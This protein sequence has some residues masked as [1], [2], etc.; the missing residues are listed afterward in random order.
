MHRRPARLGAI[1][2]AGLTASTVSLAPA[3]AAVAAV[4][5]G[6]ALA[7]V[8]DQTNR[9]TAEEKVKAAAVLGIDPDA[10]LLGYN[11]QQFVFELW[12]KAKDGSAVKA[13]A[14]RAYDDDA[15]DAAYEFIT[16]G[17]FTAQHDD[18]QTEIIAAQG[19]ALRRSVAVKVGLDP[20][21]TALIE[22]DDFD[23]IDVIFHRATAGTRLYEAARAATADG[24]TQQDWTA[25]L[26][27]GAAA[28]VDADLADQIAKADAE[29]AAKLRAEQMA[30]AKRSLLQL[31]L[32]PVSE[33]LINAPSRQFVLAVH[34]QAKG[35]EVQLASQAVLNAPD[36]ELAKALDDFILTGGAAANTRDEQAA[37]AKELAGY[38]DRVTAIRDSVRT[39][40]KQP[41]LLAAADQALADGGLVA[42]QTFLLKGQDEARAKDKVFVKQHRGN[43][44]GSVTDFPKR[45]DTVGGSTVVSAV[46]FT[47]D[48]RTDLVHQD[49]AGELKGWAS[50]GDLSADN[51]LFVGTSHIVG[52]G[53]TR[54]NAPLIIKGDFN[55]DFKADII[56]LTAK[57]ELLA[58]PSSGDMSADNKLFRGPSHLV[59]GGWVMPTVDHFAKDDW[60]IKGVITG[61]FNGDGKTDIMRHTRDDKL[62]A[63]ASTGDM[64][65]DNKLFAGKSHIVGT[66][67]TDDAAEQIVTGD[68]NGDGK[69]DIIRQ[70]GDGQLIAWA[71]TGDLSA[72]G[73]LFVRAR[74][75]GGGWTGRNVPKLITGDFNGDGK[76]DIMRQ[77]ENGQIDVWASTGDLSADNKLFVQSRVV[78]GGWTEKSIPRIITGDFNGD[79]KTDIVGQDTDGALRAWA[80]TGDLSGDNKLFPTKRIVGGGWIESRYPRIL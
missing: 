25:F 64:S 80:S 27:K 14:L 10:A 39:D 78:G 53:W 12:R 76:T 49:T 7:V 65:A 72:D 4:T 63:W 51:K 37:A 2:L 13:A 79:G 22:K 55:G 48:I 67:W 38:R 73:K 56:R 17:L 28:A 71:S 69:T 70:N 60:T 8:A 29:Y 43:A 26:T 5:G 3:T 57:G 74:V 35:T 41:N 44:A 24:T 54:D 59:G 36:A 18:E 45:L 40:V 68:F 23:F 47:G 16:G 34:N 30:N 33:E 62:L 77:S 9:A 20:K 19:R 58:W 46:D 50:S 61:D 66:G 32:L 6:R 15:P 21:D 11:D 52:G 42:L 1:L 75:V 31:L